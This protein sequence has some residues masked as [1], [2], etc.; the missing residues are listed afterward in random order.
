[1]LRL[2]ELR[3]DNV[4]YRANLAKTRMQSRQF[5][6]HA[7]FTLNGIKV[8]IPS[9]SL[10]VGD[11][12]ALR[13]KMKESPIYKSLLE[14]LDEFAKA[15]KGKVSGCKWIEVDA[16]NFTITIKSLPAKDDFEQIIDIQKI[17]EF[18]SK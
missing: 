18:Y 8:D 6:S 9:I 1:M 15:N 10:K 3:L 17:V 12:I 16:K 4:V 14:E 5:V 13:D 2:V 7:H 11:V